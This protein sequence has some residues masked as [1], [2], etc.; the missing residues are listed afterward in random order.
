M[1]TSISPLRIHAQGELPTRR[2]LSI[3]GD[4]TT[5]PV[6]GNAFALAGDVDAADAVTRRA[7]ALDKI[8]FGVWRAITEHERN[9]WV[10]N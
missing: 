1:Q 9:R 3:G 4:A 2:S 10:F 6:L 8:A 5:L 7:L